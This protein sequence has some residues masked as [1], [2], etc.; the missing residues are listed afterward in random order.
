MTPLDQGTAGARKTF[1]LS[2]SIGFEA[3]HYLPDATGQTHYKNIHGH[4]FQLEVT[5]KGR[6]KPDE[7]W[8]ED[9]A[10]LT[11]ELQ[12]VQAK[13]DH[14]LLNDIE[15]LENPTLENLCLWVAAFLG[16]RLPQLSQVSLARPSLGEKCALIL[17][18]G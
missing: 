9:L 12:N 16:P 13:L 11:A 2:K 3:A 14:M 7:H 8:V 1:A 5:L 15:G 6:L 18:E 4:S 17:D 10:T